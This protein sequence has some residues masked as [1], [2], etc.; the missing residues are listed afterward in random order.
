MSSGSDP[1]PDV[2]IVIVSFNTRELLRNCLRAIP[3]ACAG[4]TSEV[5]VVDNQS[6][7]G[8][9]DMVEKDFPSVRLVRSERN[10]GFAAGNNLAFKLAT[11]R[12]IYCLNPDTVS[13][14][15]SISILVDE[16]ESDQRIGYIGPKLLNSDGSHQW[17][18]YRF[19][20]VLSGFFSWSML[21]LDRRF[22][23]SKHSLSLHHKF[24]CDTPMN[25]DWITGAAIL[26]RAEII[27]EVGGFNAEY[28]LYAEEIEWCWRM[29]RAGWIGRY[30]PRAVV[31]HIRAASTSHLNDSHAFHG[32]D[33][34]LLISAHR[35]LAQQ[36]LGTTGMAV[37][38]VAHLV[39]LSVAY[40]RNI[41][42]LPGRNA[43][44]R[45]KAYLWIKYMIRTHSRKP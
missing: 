40:L 7:D 11:G 1:S 45:R 13:H 18:A 32:H 43:A 37:G 6:H 15:Q 4:R 33:P 31:T 3:A 24:G 30:E 21:G 41:P 22:P 20:T 28:F 17:S 38:F 12:F 27:G 9:A 35:R 8:S 26:T 19:H 25:V 44:T 39:G 14:P 34:V 23:D 36:T 5:F 16:L 10:L 29:H 42:P 2:S